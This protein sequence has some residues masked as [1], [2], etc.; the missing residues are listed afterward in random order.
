MRLE[1]LKIKVSKVVAM[2]KM[3]NDKTDKA[4]TYGVVMERM[5]ALLTSSSSS[6]TSL[7]VQIV[8]KVTVQM[9]CNVNKTIEG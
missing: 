9:A 3:M 1:S 7:Y 5:S 8:F 6:S 2:A 4:H